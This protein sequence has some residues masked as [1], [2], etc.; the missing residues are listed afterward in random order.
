ME[1]EVEL[2]LC[3]VGARRERDV[4]LLAAQSENVVVRKPL[5]ERPTELP[6]RAGDE[7][8]T[9]QD[10][11]PASRA[12]RIGSVVFHRRATRGSFQGIVCSSGSDGSYSSVTW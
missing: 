2:A 6:A 3:H 12:E 9:G 4:P 8:S 5:P 1:D 10:A 7:N 11:A